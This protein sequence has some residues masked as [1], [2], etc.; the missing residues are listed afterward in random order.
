MCIISSVRFEAIQEAEDGTLGI[1]LFHPVPV[2]PLRGAV[3]NLGK[4]GF[5]LFIQH[6]ICHV[7]RRSLG[8]KFY[9]DKNSLDDDAIIG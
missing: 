5:H 1:S 6:H 4:D 3:A 7:H 8:C 2:P 9:M